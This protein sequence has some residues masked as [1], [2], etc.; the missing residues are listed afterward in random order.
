LQA[1][2]GLGRTSV[3]S[4]GY[5]GYAT[6]YAFRES[7]LRLIS[8]NIGSRGYGVSSFPQLII[9]GRFS[10]GKA[11]GQPSSFRLSG[12]WWPFYFSSRVTPVL[13]LLEYVWTRLDLEFGIGGLWGE[14]L[15]LEKLNAFLLAQGARDGD[16]TGWNYQWVEIAEEDLESSEQLEPW[17]PEVLSA[18]EFA[19]I[20]RLCDG[21]VIRIDDPGLLEFLAEE[22]VDP[23]DFQ[24]RLL[25]T[26][27][28]AMA[29]TS[30]ELITDRCRTAILPDGRFIA[31]EDNSGRLT[32]WLDRYRASLRGPDGQASAAGEE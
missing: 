2:G 4:C 20:T 8:D 23:R 29:G 31:G 10:L 1:L 27:L 21:A 3:L 17:Q 26:G 30:I 13:L 9:C 24:E 6:E 15:E 11:N 19:V 16:R 22:N 18:Q 28:V 5:H 14:D 12:E 25:G 7:F 32:R